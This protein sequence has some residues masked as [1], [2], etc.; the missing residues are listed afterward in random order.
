[1]RI[2]RT[3]LSV[4]SL[5]LLW[6]GDAH[7]AQTLSLTLQNHHF[8]PNKIVVPSGK[9]FRIDI[10]NLDPSAAELESFD[11]HFEKIVVGN[12]G[13]AHVFAGPLHPG[14]VYSFFDDYN[15]DVARGTIEARDKE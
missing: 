2:M 7:A 9:R 3:I 15:P 8:T 14:V 12:G 5:S 1:M 4:G 11:M 10:T 6:V 13:Q